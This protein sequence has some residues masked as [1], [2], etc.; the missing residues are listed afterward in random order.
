[1]TVADLQKRDLQNSHPEHWAT[2]NISFSRAGWVFWNQQSQGGKALQL[3]HFLLV[4]TLQLGHFP[5]L[6]QRYT[7]SHPGLPCGKI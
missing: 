1:M 4:K 3:E 7:I 2:L 5:E 6:L